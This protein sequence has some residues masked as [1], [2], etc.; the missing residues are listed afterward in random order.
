MLQNV[1]LGDGGSVSAV[2]YA[3]HGLAMRMDGSVARL[4]MPVILTSNDFRNGYRQGLQTFELDTAAR[5]LVMREL[6]GAVDATHSL[7][8]LADERSVLIGNQAVHLRA[9]ALTAYDW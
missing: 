5:T 3:C 1:V 9:G 7:G 4:A 8:W 6:N 2:K